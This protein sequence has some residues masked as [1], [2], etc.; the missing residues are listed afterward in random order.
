MTWNLILCPFTHRLEEAETAL[1]TGDVQLRLACIA[2]GGQEPETPRLFQAEHRGQ[3]DTATHRGTPD[4][5]G[6]RTQ[7]RAKVS[8]L[9]CGP[10]HFTLCTRKRLQ[11]RCISRAV[12]RLPG[13]PHCGQSQGFTTR[14]RHERNTEEKKGAPEAGLGQDDEQ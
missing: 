6:L 7:P 1:H 11:L 3:A 9:P 13:G 4:A 8:A 10:L 12:T 2:P 14:N 5:A